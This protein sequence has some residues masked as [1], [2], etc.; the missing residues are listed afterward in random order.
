MFS[1]EI[2][3]ARG[4]TYLW[5]PWL[6]WAELLTN[7]A[8]AAALIWMTVTVARRIATGRAPNR[9]AVWS[10]AVFTLGL[11]ATHLLDVWVTWKPIYGADV[12]VRGLAALAAVVTAVALPR[13]LPA[14]DDA[15]PREQLAVT[16]SGKQVSR[17]LFDVKAVIDSVID[18]LEP[19]AEQKNLSLRRG[20][21]ES[22]QLRSDRRLLK[23]ALLHLVSNAIKFT[24]SGFV[25]ITVG[26][27]GRALTITVR[28]SGPGIPAEARA[29]I[30]EPF[31]QLAPPGTPRRSGM[32]LGLAVVKDILSRL[33]ALILL[34]SEI[35]K[36]SA[37]VIIF[38]EEG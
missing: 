23:V 5:T 16:S 38:L 18:E 27:A 8:I 35:G 37:F 33:N 14:A 29:R 30:F 25:E 15:V 20:P 4:H 26:H 3:M 2:F 34:E 24:A 36:G 6:V 12:M 19:A 1:S 21:G 32:G 13:L 22:A 9:F 11:G 28:D 17:Q 7:A 10:F 31:E